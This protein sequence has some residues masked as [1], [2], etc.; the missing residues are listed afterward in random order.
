M[1]RRLFIFTAGSTLAAQVAP[2][3]Q[4][5]VGVIGA[6]FRG[7]QLVRECLADASVRIGAVCETYEP[8]LFGA[9]ALA[10]SKGHAT[11]YYRIY[12]DLIADRDIDAVL[13]ATPDF[14]HC[15]MTLEALQ[16]GKDVYVEQPVCHSWQEG[17]ELL[18]AEKG[19]RQ[20][21]QVGSQRRSSLFFT[22]TARQLAGG[23]AGHIQIVQAL[24]TSNY[25][26][27]GVLRRGGVKFRDPL[28]F[29]DWQAGAAS[30]VPYSPDRFLNWRFYSMYGGGPVA[31]LGVHILDG[32][33]M[34]TGAA[35]PAVVKATGIR[36]KEEGFDAAERAAIVVE[37]PNGILLSLSI[38]GAAPNE[39]EHSLVEGDGGR[40]QI[41]RQPLD[42]TGRHLANFFNSVRT[43]RVPNAP[44]SKTL[45]ASLV[46]Q[47]ANLAIT[48]NRAVGWDS[49]LSRVTE[50]THGNAI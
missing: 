45:A 34:L 50:S 46:C 42:P 22:E 3:K 14:W 48:S 10:R 47:M 12:G 7:L 25:L 31:D 23:S 43:R 29:P 1:T 20:I 18:N 4:V 24:R 28:N 44:I 2:S 30:Q 38:N 5:V 35:Y 26:R 27:P 33:H 40:I 19:S 6:G 11:R 8:R 16:A 9:V 21:V 15:R 49:I 17:V 39:Q 41:D 36:S 37:Y 32:L 13:I